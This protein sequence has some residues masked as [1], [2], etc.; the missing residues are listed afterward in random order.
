MIRTRRTIWTT[1]TTM[2]TTTKMM[3]TVK[4]PQ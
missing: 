1:K 3:M 4:T 2:K